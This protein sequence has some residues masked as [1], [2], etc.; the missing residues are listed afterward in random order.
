MNTIEKFKKTK[1]IMGLIDVAK[2]RMESVEEIQKRIREVLE[3]IDEERLIAAPDCGLGFF[4]R[5][6]AKQKM[7]ILSKAVKNL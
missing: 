4:D 6:Q 3:H 1:V 2:S 7:Q 5:N